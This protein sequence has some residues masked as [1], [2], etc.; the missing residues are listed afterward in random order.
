[1]TELLR[2]Y[3]FR[4]RDRVGAHGVTVTQ[5]YA[6]EVVLRRGEVTAKELASELDLDKST[7]SRLAEGM[8][9]SG[10]LERVDNP[11]DARSQLLSVTPRGRRA[12][13]NVRRDIVDENMA[14][15]R[16]LSAPQRTMF[17][18]TF[19]RFTAAARRRIR[20]G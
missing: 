7:V 17:I 13:G 9:A 1:M 11:L 5:T 16:E 10:L 18:R 12:Y 3:Q 15:L 14:V 20:G 19:T 8:V 4:D 2:L 6:L